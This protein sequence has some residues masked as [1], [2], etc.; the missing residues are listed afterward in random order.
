MNS[1][2]TNSGLE[3]AGQNTILLILQ[4]NNYVRVVGSDFEKDFWKTSIPLNK[5]ISIERLLDLKV[6]GVLK[7]DTTFGNQDL[8]S[9]NSLFK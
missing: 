8:K 9:F 5:T 1:F 2:I 3:Q 4:N 7:E 6:I